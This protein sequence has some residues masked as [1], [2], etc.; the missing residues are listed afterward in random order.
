MFKEYAVEPEAIAA[1]WETC[2]YLVELFGFHQGRLIS[3]FPKT[4]KRLA[5]EAAGNMMPGRKQEKTVE[6]ISE[7]GKAYKKGKLKALAEVRK[8][9]LAQAKQGSAP[10]QKQMLEIIGKAGF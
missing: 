3:R 6:L 5:I 8:A 1:S 7:I 10:A 4:W 2:R 9:V